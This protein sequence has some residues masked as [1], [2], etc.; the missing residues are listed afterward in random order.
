M[1][2]A[3]IYYPA[4]FRFRKGCRPRT[5]ETSWRGWLGYWRFVNES[6]VNRWTI[7]VHDVAVARS[8]Y[9]PIAEHQ[10][11]ATLSASP[12]A[13]KEKWELRWERLNSSMDAKE[14]RECVRQMECD[15]LSEGTVPKVDDNGCRTRLYSQAPGRTK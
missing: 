5:P 2:L 9:Y 11:E 10:T 7:C 14:R 12:R 15:I 8:T 4:K 1:I 13:P 6:G 3:W